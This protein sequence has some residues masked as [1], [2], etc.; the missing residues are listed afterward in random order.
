MPGQLRILAR[1]G[2][3]QRLPGRSDRVVAV[4]LDRVAT[5]EHGDQQRGTRRLDS[6]Q[7]AGL[8]RAGASALAGSLGPQLQQ[9]G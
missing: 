5:I 1:L 3:P 7:D 2:L 9:G 8:G 6:E 4:L